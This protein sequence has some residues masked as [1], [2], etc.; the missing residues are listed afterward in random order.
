MTFN[1]PP[2]TPRHINAVRRLAIKL[3]RRHGWVGRTPRCPSCGQTPADAP[4]RQGIYFV[5]AVCA[6]NEACLGRGIDADAVFVA[7]GFA[8]SREADAW[9]EADGRTLED[10]IARLEPTAQEASVS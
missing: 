4:K 7:L 8:D 10:L 2:T 1:V 6:A 3:L 9:S 5:R